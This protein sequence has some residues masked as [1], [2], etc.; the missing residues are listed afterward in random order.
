MA[1]AWIV[2]LPALGEVVYVTLAR[3]LKLVGTGFAEK[4]PPAPASLKVTGIPE[5]AF[6]YWSVTFTTSC[7]ASEVLGGAD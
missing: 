5:T 7:C 4:L 2:P 3:P 1:V 6:P